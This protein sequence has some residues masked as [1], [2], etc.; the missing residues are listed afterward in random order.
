MIQHPIHKL[1]KGNALLGRL[2]NLSGDRGYQ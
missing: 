1:G 2:S